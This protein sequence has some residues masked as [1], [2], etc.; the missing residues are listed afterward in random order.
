[1][2]IKDFHKNIKEL[3]PEAFN[4]KWLDSYDHVYIDLNYLLHYCSYSSNSVDDIMTKIYSLIDIIL[5]ETCPTKSI[6][7]TTD[8][9][10]P[11]SKL[12]VQRKRRQTIST[13]IQN[14]EC[15]S[16]LFTP[17]TKFMNNLEENMND[18]IE[19]IKN[20]YFVD[21]EFLNHHYDE[22]ELKLK[23]KI[24]E[25]IDNNENDTHIFISNDADVIVMLTSLEKYENVF[26]YN[27]Q[28]HETEIISI[29]KLLDL[30]TD[31]Y[32]MSRNCGLD[33]M[34]IN[35]ML[36]NDYIPKIISLNFRKIWEAY[37]WALSSDKCGLI[38]DKT[39]KINKKFL[40]KMMIYIIS[41]MNKRMQ[42]TFK[43]ESFYYES[44]HNYFDG[45]TWCLNMYTTGKCC[46]Y[47]YMCGNGAIHPIGI[48]C[49]LYRYD[50]LLNIND[51]RENPI[52]TSLY[53]I[54][55]LPKISKSLIDKKYYDFMD[56]NKILYDKECCETCKEYDIKN[57]QLLKDRRLLMESDNNELLENK[58]NE[59]S[60]MKIIIND[61]NKTHKDISVI[62][63]NKIEKIYMKYIS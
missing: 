13:K 4:V 49:I 18:Y 44:Y 21:I 52:D 35:I 38:I 56:K 55:L 53:A 42:R 50:D 30:H 60:E 32:G 9:S 40:I 8:G 31:R 24:M 51:G 10:A 2:G 20:T 54:L 17:G 43:Y 45:F 46:R 3:Y 26:V 28:K 27:R 33:F 7:F 1:M 47:D 58:R 5:H 61:H 36:G 34:A 16:L 22:A 14:I 48:M 23:Y 25:N 6:T 62:D 11:L 63:I 39:L 29:L 57:K 15:S 19:S 12:L 41:T 37:E 59:L